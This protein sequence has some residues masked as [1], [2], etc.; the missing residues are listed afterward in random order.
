MKRF[1]LPFKFS[2][3]YKKLFSRITCSLLVTIL[4]ILLTFLIY[5]N[6]LVNKESS[7]FSPIVCI[8]VILLVVSIVQVFN[9]HQKEDLYIYHEYLQKEIE[10]IELFEDRKNLLEITFKTRELLNLVYN[11]T[12]LSK[13]GVYIA[14]FLEHDIAKSRKVLEELIDDMLFMKLGYFFGQ[15]PNEHFS[16]AIYLYDTEQDL[17]WDFVSIKDRKI[18]PKR[19]AGRVWRRQDLSHIAFCFNH[20]LELIHSDITERFNEFG[21]PSSNITEQDAKNYKSAITLPI[22]FRRENQFP[23]I[24]G[25]FCLTSDNIGTFHETTNSVTDPIYSLKI[26]ALR[27]VTEIIADNLALLYGNNP[28]EIRQIRLGNITN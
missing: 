22:F 5:A 17:L 23:Q 10:N 11:F 28:L 21:M 6:D 16:I 13:T 3:A 1:R 25:V 18:N 27:M 20:Q 19:N 4:T 7:L 2:D 24:V 15:V 12:I 14:S 9:E 26:L 8:T